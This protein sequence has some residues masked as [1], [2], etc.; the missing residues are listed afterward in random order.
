MWLL[1]YLFYQYNTISEHIRE[2]TW[3]SYHQYGLTN[4]YSS[5]F[6]A[7]GK[8]ELSNTLES[9]WHPWELPWSL[10]CK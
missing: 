10:S 3:C 8:I 4:I 7:N 2:V 9:L 5:G 6:Q 1:N